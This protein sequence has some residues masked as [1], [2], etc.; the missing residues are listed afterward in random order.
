MSYVIETF[1]SRHLFIC[2]L[3]FLNTDKHKKLGND[4][5]V[6]AFDTN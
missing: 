1:G 5:I 2:S 6:F 3:A 4:E